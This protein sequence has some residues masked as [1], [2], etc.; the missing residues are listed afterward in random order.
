MG[1]IRLRYYNFIS[2]LDTAF[3][4]YRRNFA[5]FF[6]ITAVFLLLPNLLVQIVSVYY[7]GPSD[8]FDRLGTIIG[9]LGSMQTEGLPS[10]ELDSIQKIAMYALPVNAVVMILKALWYGPLINAIHRNAV[11]GG[12]GFREAFR[13]GWRKYL[14]LF[15]GLILMVVIYVAIMSPLIIGMF[16]AV[17]MGGRLSCNIAAFCGL[18]LLVSGASIFAMVLLTLF[19]Q[20]IVIEDKGPLE[21]LVRSVRLIWGYWWWAFAIML[22]IMLIN[23][24]IYGVAEWSFTALNT[25]ILMMKPELEI[26]G[27][28]LVATGLTIVQIFILPIMI[29][30]Q[31]IL[32]YDLKT[33]REAYDIE[34]MIKGF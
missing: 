14:N 30:V 9:M 17:A 8:L 23:N 13:I 11:G 2:L 4:L 16:A 20:S 15:F 33:R 22:T 3:S 19:Y 7:I 12:C 24:V 29:L 1:Q 25:F 34:V 26:F 18:S 27:G 21:A 32:F 5:L 10:D 6:W 31:T 28:A